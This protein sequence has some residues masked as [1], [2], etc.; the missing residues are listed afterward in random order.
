LLLSAVSTRE[1]LLDVMRTTAPGSKVRD[2]LVNPLASLHS[3]NRVYCTEYVV[4]LNSAT[5]HVFVGAA[6]NS[7]VF[8]CDKFESRHGNKRL[9]VSV[10]FPNAKYPDLSTVVATHPAMQVV[11]LYAV[12][13]FVNTAP[14]NAMKLYENILLMGGNRVKTISESRLI[15]HICCWSSSARRYTLFE[16]QHPQIWFV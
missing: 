3:R 4:L 6:C 1:V 2:M 14:P 7:T 13:I 9:Y 5:A 11:R 15:F 10:S 12:A 16:I 8:T